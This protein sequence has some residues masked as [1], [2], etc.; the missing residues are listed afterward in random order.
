MEVQQKPLCV[1]G[2]PC[3]AHV[4]V[5]DARGQQAGSGVCLTG[6]DC[7][8]LLQG[9]A[10]SLP[11]LEEGKGQAQVPWACAARRGACPQALQAEGLA[12]PTVPLPILCACSNTPGCRSGVTVRDTAGQGTLTPFLVLQGMEL[13]QRPAPSRRQNQDKLTK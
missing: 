1:K 12:R 8:E 11:V 10:S 2:T 6:S 9:T 7:S 4:E 13:G 5:S 3:K